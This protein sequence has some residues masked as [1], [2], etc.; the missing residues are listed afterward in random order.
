MKEFISSLE[1]D[2]LKI[3]ESQPALLL[4]EATPGT[5]HRC[6]RGLKASFL[7]LV[8]LIKQSQGGP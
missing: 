8:G 5:A 7:D 3:Q 6:T 2:I 1:D 4:P